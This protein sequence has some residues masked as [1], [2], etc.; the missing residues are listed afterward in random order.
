MEA[1]EARELEVIAAKIGELEE[2]HNDILDLYAEI[3]DNI[4]VSK[5]SIRYQVNAIAVDITALNG[6]IRRTIAKTKKATIIMS[7]LAQKEELTPIESR[8][9]AQKYEMYADS[10]WFKEELNNWVK[11]QLKN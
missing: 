6:E 5:A 1:S 4:E 9:N 8:V 10:S 7:L 11:K 2:R 3:H